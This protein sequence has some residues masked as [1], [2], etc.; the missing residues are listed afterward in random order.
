VIEEQELTAEGQEKFPP[1]FF[2]PPV[3]FEV[4][5]LM[6]AVQ[7]LESG[8]ITL[9]PLDFQRIL[10]RYGVQPLP[11]ATRL[12]KPYWCGIA[13]PTDREP[14][15]SLQMLIDDIRLFFAQ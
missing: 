14:P 1:G 9:L 5:D 6:A 13:H 4:E 2:P 15:L 8:Y 11:G 10:R 12:T 7:L 3:A